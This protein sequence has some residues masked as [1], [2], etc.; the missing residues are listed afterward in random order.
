MIDVERLSEEI[1]R[2]ALESLHAHCPP[3]TRSALGLHLVEVGDAL[4]AGAARDPSVLLN[5]TLGLGTRAVP[6]TG[7]V[8]EI[9]RLYRDWDVPRYFLHLYEDDVPDAVVS[10]A[11]GIGLRPTRGWM[12]F[13]RNAAPAT[14][15]GTDLELRRVGPKAAM[16]FG[17]I[18]ARAFGM[19]EAAAPL[20]AGLANDPNWYLF[21]S[22]EADTPAGAGALYV[23]GNA[24]WTE[25]GATEPAF[26]RRGSQGAIMAERINTAVGLGCRH[27]FTETGEAVDGDPQHSYGNILRFGFEELRLRQ[28]F[29]PAPPT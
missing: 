1:E 21:L 9:V 26:R 25:W 28:N 2:D 8:D 4:V 11:V 13:Q 20:L 19:T 29:A 18:V 7:Q 27:I 12:K 15:R 6:A 3:E 10:H 23:S 17:S 16:D 14:P 22:Y 5:R 24:A